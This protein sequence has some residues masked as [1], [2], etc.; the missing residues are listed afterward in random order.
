[1]AWFSYFLLS[2]PEAFFMILIAFALV[3]IA[4]KENIKSMIIFSFLYGGVAF[5]LSTYMQTS[6]KPLITFIIF[7]LLV[8]GVFHIKLING[9][10]ISL[11]AFFFLHTYE[12]IFILLYVQI[13]PITIEQIV[14]SP[15]LRILAGYFA[16]QIPILITTLVLLKFN[17]KI[18]L[19]LLR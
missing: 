17:L 8:A 5:L 12:I 7:G 10:I 16:V 6:L 1:M 2:V 13:F 9:F 18:K 11:I 14:S 15:W 19:P 4:I 3:N